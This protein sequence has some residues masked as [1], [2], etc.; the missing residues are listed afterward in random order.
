M[1][2]R[3][4]AAS[5]SSEEVVPHELQHLKCS[6]GRLGCAPLHLSVV[7][8]VA[9][10]T[11][12]LDDLDEQEEKAKR[13]NDKFREDLIE[14]QKELRT[15]KVELEQQLTDAVSR[16]SSVNELRRSLS[17]EVRVHLRESRAH[18]ARC[19]EAA[20]KEFETMCGLRKVRS[21]LVGKSATITLN[22][23]VDC[24]VTDWQPGECS[25]RCD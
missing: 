20:R 24:D 25:A 16:M 12:T 5:N 4:L 9:E 19:K 10:T 3:L 13:D 8:L 2:Q 7:R 11:D 14:Q 6:F 1:L 15:R 21:S 18:Q 22:D 17:Q 23:V